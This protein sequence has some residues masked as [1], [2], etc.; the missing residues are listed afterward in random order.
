MKNRKFLTNSI[1]QFS[2]FFLIINL[3]FFEKLNFEKLKIIFSNEALEIYILLI[4]SRLFA[5]ILFT[6]IFNILLKKKPFFKI[7]EIYLKGH[8]VNEAVPGLGYFYRYKKSKNKFGISILEYGSIQTLNNL[9]ILLSLL[10]LAF[11]LGF[12]KIVSIKIL[13]ISV[14]SV[15]LLIFIFFIFFKYRL[16][17]LNFKNIKKIY[18]EFSVIKKNFNKNYYKFIILFVLYLV[19]SLFQCYIFYQITILFSFELGFIYSS[20]LYIGSILI[21][22]LFFLNFIGLFELVLSFTSSFFI[23]NYSDMIFVGLGFR[24]MGI[25]ALVLIILT[26]YIFNYLK[27][28]KNY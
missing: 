11:L 12:I 19:Q 7:V 21:T 14:I 20:Y 25:I 13:Y 8:L 2:I 22:F 10:I 28:K 5:P 3:F 4:F 9:F 1:L 27:K 17:F 18:D 15:L 23:K 26:F 16:S 24:L 6:F